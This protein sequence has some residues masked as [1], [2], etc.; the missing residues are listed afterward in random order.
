MKRVL[1]LIL[2]TPILCTTALFTGGCVT[3]ATV[4]PGAQMRARANA[5]PKAREIAERVARSMGGWDAWE[6]TRFVTWHFFGGRAHAW[7]KQ[8]NDWRL[9]NGE[10]VVLM[11]A[12]TRQGRVFDKGVE[13]TDAAARDK[14]LQDAYGMWINDS[15]WMFMPWKL[16]DPG[17]EL[18]YLGAT[19]LENGRTAQ[20]LELTFE[21]VGL[22][23][24]NRYVVAVGDESG[25]VEQWSYY[26]DAND[27]EPKLTTPWSG[28]E[29]RGSILV[30]TDHGERK[31]AKPDWKI[32]VP[33]DLPRA[34]FTDPAAKIP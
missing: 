20:L 28:W 4:S 27:A 7:D 22:T 31:G 3:S 23:P 33:A 14:A 24:K 29:R 8:T 1:S 26:A 5:E 30:C 12:D 2:C 25:L 21:N 13:L 32:D 18:R 17:V 16:L 9:E 10:R 19:T 6:R 11:N 34:V 15:Y